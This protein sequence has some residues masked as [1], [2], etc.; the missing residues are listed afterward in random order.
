LPGEPV[1]V[2]ENTRIRTIG[3]V[4]ATKFKAQEYTQDAL[5]PQLI[6]RY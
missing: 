1:L 5:A 6:G 3:A 4:V 2:E